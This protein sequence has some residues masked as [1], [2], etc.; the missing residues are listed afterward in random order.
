M[1]PIYVRYYDNNEATVYNLTEE[2]YHKILEE[3]GDEA[4]DLLDKFALKLRPDGAGYE[5]D[6]VLKLAEIYGFE[7]GSE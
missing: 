1:S 2:Q 3:G 7:V 6:F 4:T 5:R